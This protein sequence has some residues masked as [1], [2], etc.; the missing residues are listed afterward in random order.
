M[1]PTNKE[2]E[3]DNRKIMPGAEPFL[4]V[5]GDQGCL[6]IHGISGS[7]Q[8]FRETGEHLY[9]AGITAHGILLAGH[10]TRVNDLHGCTYNDWLHSAERGMGRLKQQCRTITCVGLSMGGVIALRLAQLY[11]DQVDGVVTVCSPYK[12][13]RLKFKLV[14]FAKYLIKSVAGGPP[15]I[16]DPAAR[17]IHYAHHSLPAVHQLIMLTKLVQEDLP[18]IRQPALIVG[19]E[20]DKVVDPGDAAIIYEAIGSQ[21]KELLMLKNSQHVAPLDFDRPILNDKILAFITKKV[22]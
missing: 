7:P 8:V 16:N 4:L 11:P 6:L 9:R 15:S 19:A 3:T 2:P 20:Q 1:I 14:P 13:A 5:A 18:K 21:D 10:G 22:K 12:L 17:E